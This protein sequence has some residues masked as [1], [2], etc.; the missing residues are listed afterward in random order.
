M[1][2]LLNKALEITKNQ[3]TAN[4]YHSRLQQYQH[5][6]HIKKYQGTFALGPAT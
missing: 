6:T 1:H 2:R 3:R 4:K 5:C